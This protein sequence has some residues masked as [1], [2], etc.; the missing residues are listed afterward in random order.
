MMILFIYFCV[1]V[2]VYVGACLGLCCL[3]CLA[4]FLVTPYSRLDQVFWFFFCIVLFLPS[5]LTL[6]LVAQLG[7]VAK[8]GEAAL[9]F[10]SVFFPYCLP[11]A[12][13]TLCPFLPPS[14]PHCALRKRKWCEFRRRRMI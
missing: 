7:D 5:T 4:A 6:D 13:F 8:C 11:V 10:F 9:F 2:F 12:Y 14:C 1:R 3:C